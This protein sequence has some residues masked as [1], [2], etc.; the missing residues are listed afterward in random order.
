M[1]V[2][3]QRHELCANSIHNSLA[4]SNYRYGTYIVDRSSYCVLMQEPKCCFMLAAFFKTLVS[5]L[6]SVLV[7]HSRIGLVDGFGY[8][9]ACVG[10]ISFSY[11]K[12]IYKSESHVTT[13]L[14]YI[15]G[16]AESGTV[17]DGASKITNEGSD[18]QESIPLYV[19]TYTACKMCFY[20]LP[21]L[22]HRASRIAT[23]C[24]RVYLQCFH[25]FE[26]DSFLRCS[27]S[28]VSCFHHFVNLRLYA[29]FGGLTESVTHLCTW[30]GIVKAVLATKGHYSLSLACHLCYHL[31]V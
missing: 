13:C 22:P 12:S 31:G 1:R 11:C 26:V 15:R 8:C 21:H 2:R 5:V 28:T 29:C 20:G 19:N 3:D 30:Y 17:I 16:D 4:S 14:R 10:A 25:F 7:F 6:L 18:A 24:D 27:V 9:I 23:Y